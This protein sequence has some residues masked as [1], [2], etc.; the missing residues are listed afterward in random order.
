[1]RISRVQF[2]L[3][4]TIRSIAVIAVVLAVLVAASRLVDKA[5]AD[6][7]KRI[8]LDPRGSDY[9][10]RA[11]AWSGMKEY[12]KAIA[13][14]NEA[15]RLAPDSPY[16]YHGRA[17]V[18]SATQE[19]DK[20]IGD[21]NEAI[22]LYTIVFY[23]FRDGSESG[24]SLFHSLAVALGDAHYGRGNVWLAKK[25][26]DRALSDY[27][28]FTHLNPRV[29]SAYTCR[30]AVWQLKGE[31]NKALADYREAIQIDPGMLSAYQGRAWIWA[32]C[33]DPPFRDG[34]KAVESATNACEL[35]HCNDSGSL[36][37]LAAA[38][39]EL[40]EFDLAVRRQTQAIAAITNLGESDEQRAR[41]MLYQ[42]KKPYR[43][44]H[45]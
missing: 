30:A 17:A 5:T 25:E 20:A 37:A 6:F 43:M 29:P 26:Y 15:I 40:G 31:F 3:R 16:A 22:R 9:C 23:P 13:G 7:Y 44:Q 11:A 32:A 34:K 42:E 4:W 28:E 8:R 36:E 27:A 35:T 41:L 12:G 1:M 24:E 10:D 14:Y 33:P 39:A 45:Q 19:Y 2:K 18:W 38:H 21:Y